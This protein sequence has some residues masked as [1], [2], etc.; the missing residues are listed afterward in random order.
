[1]SDSKGEDNRDI[2][3]TRTEKK[4]LRTLIR[5]RDFLRKIIAQ[6]QDDPQDY[7]RA[8]EAALTW[9]VEAIRQMKADAAEDNDD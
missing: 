6:E 9:G 5:R 7:D 1:M 4:R 3:F 8:E 2:H